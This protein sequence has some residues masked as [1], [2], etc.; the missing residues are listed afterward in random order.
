MLPGHPGSEGIWR[1]F[2]IM[3]SGGYRLSLEGGNSDLATV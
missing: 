1:L 3:T 2:A